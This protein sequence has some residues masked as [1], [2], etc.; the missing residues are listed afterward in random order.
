[1]ASVDTT[2]ALIEALERHSAQSSAICDNFTGELLN[3][4]KPSVIYH[5][6]DD[7]G[8]KGIPETGKL[9]FTDLFS[10]NDP[11]ELDHGMKHAFKI[12][13]AQVEQET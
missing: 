13:I 8:L 5:Y 10:L 4:P 9:W 6:T 2:K 7:K 1:M 11:S 3:A 12:L